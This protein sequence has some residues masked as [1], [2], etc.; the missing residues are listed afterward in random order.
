ME[1]GFF[2]IPG[3]DGTDDDL[4]E[5]INT[6]SD[7]IFICASGNGD[8]YGNPY[9]IDSHPVS[10]ASLSCA[11]I[12]TVAATDPS[13]TL[14]S[15]SNY[16]ATTVDVAAPGVSIYSTYPVSKGSYTTMDGTSMATPHVAGLAALVKAVNSGYTVAQIKSTIMNGVDTVS[17]LSGKC[18]TGGR[19]N[20]GKSIGI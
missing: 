4:E 10:P 8:K 13:D 19:V 17:G 2:P 1:P 11:N 6:Y 14:A 20:T 3:G 12:V 18:V 16:G 5:A 9:N 7:A 15:W